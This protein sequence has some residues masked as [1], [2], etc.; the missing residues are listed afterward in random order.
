MLSLFW[1]MSRR[2]LPRFFEEV[3]AVEEAEGAK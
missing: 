3:A 2:S 1:L